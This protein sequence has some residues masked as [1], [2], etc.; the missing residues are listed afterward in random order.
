[1]LEELRDCCKRQS[2]DND[3]PIAVAVSGGMD[4]MGLLFT[5]SK[6]FKNITVLHVN[7]HLRGEDS[8]KDEALV[9]DFCDLLKVSFK[10][11]SI[12]IESQDKS[13]QEEARNKR[14]DW[15]AKESN[16]LGLNYVFIAHHLDD[17]L[18]TF[19]MNLERGSGLTG[20]SG[21]SEKNGYY[22]R[23]LLSLQKEDVKQFVEKNEVPFREDGSNSSNKYLRNALRNKVI[24]GLKEELPQLMN[25][26]K[27]SL[28]LIEG[29]NQLLTEKVSCLRKTIMDTGSFSFDSLNSESNIVLSS[30]FQ[31]WGLPLFEYEKLKTS[32]AN[33]QVGSVYQ[34]KNG[35]VLV[36]RTCLKF[37]FEKLESDTIE[38]EGKDCIIDM[39]YAKIEFR[40]VKRSEVD[41]TSGVEYID[42]DKLKFPL[43]LRRWRSGDHFRPLGMKGMKK[44]SDFLIDLKV[45]RFEKDKV[46]VLTSEEKIVN[47]LSFRLDERFKIEKDSNCV[48]LVHLK[49]KEND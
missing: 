8:D 16:S 22:I 48:Y 36:D 11:K 45:D 9:K 37:R 38:I 29:S 24:P 34:L 25:G 6:F 3:D 47:V 10:S 30:L 41:F 4:S 49:T 35:E 33:N 23:P 17:Q 18:E 20:L 40:R 2:I 28:S 5:C 44:V 26:L 27:K 13:I 15:F 42:G 31:E 1:M 21:M 39:P 14:Y 19:L 12:R 32:I 7:Y 46:W 43:Q